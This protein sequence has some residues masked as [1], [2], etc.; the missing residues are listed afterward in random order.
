MPAC[1]TSKAVNR[2]NT[3]FWKTWNKLK[4]PEQSK[5]SELKTDDFVNVFKQNFI[6]SSSNKSI[7]NKFLE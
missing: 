3:T 1:S 6:V 7:Y 5:T 2:S 4:R